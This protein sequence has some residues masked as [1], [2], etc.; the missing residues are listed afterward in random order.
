[1]TE[2]LFS[3]QAGRRLEVHEYGDPSGHPAFFFH[4]LIGSHHQASYVDE[5]ARRAGI[6][7]IA[8][9][10]PGVGRS[11]FVARSTPLDVA[12]DIEVLARTLGLGT[13][14]VIGLSGGTPYAMAVLRRFSDRVE[15]AT[16]LSGMGP[17]TLPGALRG[18]DPRRRL[19]LAIGARRTALARQ[20]FEKS[21]SRYRESPETFLDRLIRTWSAPDREMFRRPEVYNLFMKDLEEVFSNPA[22][23]ASLAQE[24]A[25]YR[26]RGLSPRDLPAGHR[27]TLWHGLSDNIV[28]PSMAWTMVRAL[29]NA[30]AHLL[31]GGHFLAIDAA[32]AIIAWLVEQLG[33]SRDGSG[34][35]SRR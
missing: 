2:T 11:E 28:P 17:S 7:V 16:I 5:A 13:F 9:N 33:S 4:G 31:P 24:L 14:S 34:R 6:R 23:A 35:P 8:P 29:P 25:I 3:M 20:F 27:V 18:M 22:A 15:T 30:E 26:W 1:M 12:A 21:E 19:I 32:G 10:R